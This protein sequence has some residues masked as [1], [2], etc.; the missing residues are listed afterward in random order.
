VLAVLDKSEGSIASI[1]L[2]AIKKTVNINRKTEK[3]NSRE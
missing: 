3:L 1:V 2:K